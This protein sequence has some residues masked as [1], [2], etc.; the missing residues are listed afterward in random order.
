MGSVFMKSEKC[1]KQRNK[2]QER[3]DT[4]MKQNKVQL[5]VKA[6]YAGFMIGIGG[7]VYLSVENKVVGSLLFSFGLLTIVAQ[8]FNLYT[9]KIGFVK[10]P[11]ELLD[12]AGIAAGNYVG[13]LIAAWT[14]KLAQ[15]PIT[16]MALA[17]AKLE[18]P[19]GKVFFLSVLCGVMMYLAI[20]NYAKTKNIVLIIAPV[21]IFILS[22]FEH[23][24]ANM[25]YFHLA[26]AYTGKSAVYLLL[27][28]LGNGVG[29]KLFSLKD[30]LNR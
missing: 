19:A 12:M 26:G 7:M 10:K 13:T 16:S 29:A 15:L 22:G 27:M 17:E 21:M 14:A 24:I 4:G 3:A 6:V 5:V 20:D 2:K 1:Q 11:K 28:L 23:S 25:F 8:G 30:G 18:N 9:G